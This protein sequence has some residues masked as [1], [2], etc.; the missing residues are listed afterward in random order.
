MLYDIYGE[1]YIE[2]LQ[3]LNDIL[4]TNKLKQLDFS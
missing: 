3:N 1:E 2:F 4:I